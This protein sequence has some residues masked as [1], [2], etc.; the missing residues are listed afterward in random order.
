MKT[1]TCREL[2]GACDTPFTAETFEEIAEISKQ[3]GMQMFQQKDAAHL[4]AIEE[5]KTIM[6]NPEAMQ[7]WFEAKRAQFE[8]LPNK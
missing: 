6:Q 7:K 3:H 1:M 5:M 8:S 2:G 4:K